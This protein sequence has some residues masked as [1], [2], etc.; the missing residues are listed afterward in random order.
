M[1]FKIL[2]FFF[3]LKMGKGKT[4][5]LRLCFG[6]FIFLLAVF[7]LFWYVEISWPV[8]VDSQITSGKSM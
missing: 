7:L 6:L 2:F 1:S 5:F 4:V 3:F 8:V